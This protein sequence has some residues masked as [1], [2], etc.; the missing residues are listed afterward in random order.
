VEQ[1]LLESDSTGHYRF[2]VKKEK[3]RKWVSPQI[4]QILEKSSKDFG[5]VF[6]IDDPDDVGNV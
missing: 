4:K 3:S 1:G 6:D 2:R 5:Q